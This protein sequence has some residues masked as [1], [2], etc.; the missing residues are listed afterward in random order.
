M[1]VMAQSAREAWAQIAATRNSTELIEELNSE[2][3]RPPVSGTTRLLEPQVPVVLDGEVV[4]D[5]EQLN[6]ALPLNFTRLSYEGS[7]A[8]GAFTDRKAMLSEV[9]RMNGDTR[10]DFGL[11]SHTRVWEDGNEGGDRLELEAGFHWR[12]LT[13]VPRGFLHTQNWNDIISSVSVCAFNVELFDD[14]HLSGARFFID[15]HNRIPDLTPFGFNDRTSS[16]INYG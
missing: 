16:F 7:V 10:G 5:L 15:R 6:A 9:R 3:P 1:T 11:P 12:D 13:R 4:D 2:R 8:L 14:I